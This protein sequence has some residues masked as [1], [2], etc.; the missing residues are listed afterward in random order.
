[1]ID[2]PAR[3]PWPKNAM[4]RAPVTVTAEDAYSRRSRGLW[5]RRAVL[6]TLR[7]APATTTRGCSRP[8]RQWPSVT[9]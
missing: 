9:A 8:H 4:I 1:M 5:Y 6:R 2:R 3:I 7:P